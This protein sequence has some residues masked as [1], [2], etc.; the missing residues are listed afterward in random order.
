MAVYTSTTPPGSERQTNV[1]RNVWRTRGAN[2]YPT[3]GLESV[4]S[5]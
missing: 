4:T 3:L 2:K 5:V 1:Q